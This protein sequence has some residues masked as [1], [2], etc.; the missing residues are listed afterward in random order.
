MTGKRILIAD[1][2]EDIVESIKFALDQEGFEVVTANDGFEAF[3][4]TGMEKPDLVI[5][6]VMM[7]KE[8]GYKVSRAIKDSIAAGLY[9]KDIKVLL[10]TARV[11]NEPDREKMFMNMSQ[12]DHM[13]Y[14]PFEMGEL[15][16][17]INEL[18][19]E[20]VSKV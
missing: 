4:L 15:L 5:L 12:A 3:A 16:G 18:L 10:L 14:K 2:E 20:K 8:N 1:D 9:G 19:G 7:P 11:L 13:M 6:D 17:K